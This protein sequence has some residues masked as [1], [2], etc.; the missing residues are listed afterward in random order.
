MTLPFITGTD[1]SASLRKHGS[2]LFIIIMSGVLFNRASFIRVPKLVWYTEKQLYIV[3]LMQSFFASL[4][5]NF[6]LN[7]C[8]K[9][10]VGRLSR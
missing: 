1:I 4:I 7:V 10:Y 3:Y 2:A 5:N 8:T 6:I 9:K